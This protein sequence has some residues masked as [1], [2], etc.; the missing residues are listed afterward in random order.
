MQLVFALPVVLA[1]YLLGEFR[2]VSDLWNPSL[3]AWMALLSALLAALLTLLIAWS[4]PS[5]WSHAT[6]QRYPPDDWIAWRKP[7][8]L[9]LW[10][11]PL[12]TLVMLVVVG[13]GV[14]LLIGP[15]DIDLQVQLFSTRKLQIVSVLAVSTVVP[16]AEE[17]IFRGALY[18]ALL[19]SARAGVPFWRRHLAPFVV[20]SVAFALMHLLAGFST[21][22]SLVMVLLLSFYLTALRTISASILPSIVGHMVWNLIGALVIV[23]T[24]GR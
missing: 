7:H 18:N 6:A 4:W 11:V 3:L 22:A 13:Y 1:T 21:A 24:N 23:L 20:S 2:T 19:S 12:L 8:T 9:P 14:T 17:I 5:V 16:L 10:S 15:A